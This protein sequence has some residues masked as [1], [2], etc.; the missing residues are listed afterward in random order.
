[1][2]SG[3]PCGFARMGAYDNAECRMQNEGDGRLRM[4]TARQGGER[5]RETKWHEIQLGVQKSRE[6]KGNQAPARTIFFRN[7]SHKQGGKYESYDNGLTR[8]RSFGPRGL[9]ALP[10]LLSPPPRRLKSSNLN[11]EIQRGG[12]RVEADG[13]S[14][15]T[16]SRLFGPRGPVASPNGAP[17]LAKCFPCSRPSLSRHAN[18]SPVGSFTPR[19]VGLTAFAVRE[20]FSQ[21]PK[22]LKSQAA[23]VTRFAM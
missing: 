22:L 7:P 17:A 21:L 11:L 13:R 6:I 8:S 4:A 9:L 16:R 19:S 12:E 14:G 20:S 1:M 15:L 10:R 3:C 5:C 23:Q 18:L 2:D